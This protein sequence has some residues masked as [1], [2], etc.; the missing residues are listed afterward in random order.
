M[1]EIRNY[2]I[3]LT[4]KEDLN[5]EETQ[6]C[7]QI[8]SNRGATPA[9]I[10]AFLV[11]LKL[12]GETV[13]EIVAASEFL[14]NH[15]TKIYPNEKF[16]NISF[17]NPYLTFC[18]SIILNSF[19]YKIA[20]PFIDNSYIDSDMG[21]ILKGLD[22]P[23]N[24]NEEQTN[25]I[26]NSTGIYLLKE[27]NLSKVLIETIPL[28]SELGIETLIDIISPLYNLPST[29][30]HLIENSN[31]LL[32]H[33]IKE[34]N[35][36]I[37][38]TFYKKNIFVHINMLKNGEILTIEV[39]LQNYFNKNLDSLLE[40]NKHSLIDILQGKPFKDLPLL[41]CACA[42][43]LVTNGV[44]SNIDQAI[45]QIEAALKD[46]H[47]YNNFKKIME[48]SNISLFAPSLS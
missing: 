20:L 9:Q 33:S 36:E 16:L 12:K 48:Q 40:L 1:S 45:T 17:K 30:Y 34:L 7:L 14:K 25:T 39:N 21:N 4:N 44:Y 19:G 42:L 24:L 41:I 11:A 6:R 23:T 18:A 29:K 26:F 8:I 47:V 10:A 3:K 5:F 37:G 28:K 46:G 22:L 32:I 35:A 15:L 31:N 13:G 38:I 2:I 27:K 43:M